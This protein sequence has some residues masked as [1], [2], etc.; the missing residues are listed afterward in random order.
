[1]VEA[2]TPL[3]QGIAVAWLGGVILGSFLLSWTLTEVVRV[4]RALY[5]TALTAAAVGGTAAYAVLSGEGTAFWVR[6]WPWGVVGAVLAGSFLA[7]MLSRRPGERG[8]S[9]TGATVLG[10]GLVYGSAEGLLLSVLPVAIAWQLLGSLGWGDVWRGAGALAASVV[11]IVAHHLGY[12]Q[13]RG[14][15]MISPVIGCSVLSLAYLM[16]GSPIAAMGG[17]V[18]LHLAMLLRGME[19][20]PHRASRPLHTT[21]GRLTRLGDGRRPALT[22]GGS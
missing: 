17:H 14:R 2:D 15:A 13:Y 10:E 11:V 8:T 4:S 7:W 20:P 19:L 1:M 3:A 5:V 16:T 9:P 6:R 21:P 18:V 12:P 22:R